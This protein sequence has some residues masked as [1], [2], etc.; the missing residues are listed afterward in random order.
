MLPVYILGKRFEILADEENH[1]METWVI[2][3][4]P[5]D[6]VNSYSFSMVQ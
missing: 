2:D 4:R 3:G 5:G 1:I 6:D